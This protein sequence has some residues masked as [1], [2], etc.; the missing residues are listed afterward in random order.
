[1]KQTILFPLLFSSILLFGCGKPRENGQHIT[2]TGSSTVAPIVADAARRYEESHPG[3]RIDVQTG[4]SSRG[5]ADAMSG[6]ADLGMISRALK[7]GESELTA[8]LIAMDGVCV[9]VH[10]DNRIENLTRKQL[11]DIYTGKISD[12]SEIGG[13]PGEIIVAGK[14]EGR[15]TLEVFLDY[16]GL[17]SAD[18]EADVLVG[19]N[20]HAIKT[21]AGNANGIAYVSIG[22]AESESEGGTPIRLIR[23]DG[24]IPTTEA[25]AKGLFPMTRP[26]QVVTR[27][28]LP[29]ASKA[30]LSYLQTAAINDLIE[31]HFYVPVAR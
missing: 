20:Q 1:M 10:R 2:I 30:F 15:A 17:D 27:G 14:A 18:I 5:I 4:G 3:V 26:L 8:H 28:D 25:V 13:A 9:I 6:L 24:V 29:D 11:V 23:C 31:T 22:A 19:E 21:V 16:T 12:W 7:D